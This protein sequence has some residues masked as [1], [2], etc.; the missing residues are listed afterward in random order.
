MRILKGSSGHDVD[1]AW[2]V[3]GFSKG[4]KGSLDELAGAVPHHDVANFHDG[5][6]DIIVEIL[7]FLLEF[8]Q[9]KP[10]EALGV[11]EVA[12]GFGS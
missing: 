7:D 9:H 11:G 8:R 6:S 4:V 1:G 10:A 12:E 3:E 2:G 5:I